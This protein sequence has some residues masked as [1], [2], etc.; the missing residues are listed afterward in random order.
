[1]F[2][3]ICFCVTHNSHTHDQKSMK[4]SPEYTVVSN[5]FVGHFHQI[6][7]LFLVI[8]P[9]T[10]WEG[11]YNKKRGCNPVQPHLP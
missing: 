2:F 4:K 1:M 5:D 10:F 6:K 8:T 7:G 11:R 3:R 9:I